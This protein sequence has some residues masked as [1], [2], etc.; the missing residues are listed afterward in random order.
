MGAV[1]RSDYWKKGV[2]GGG[3]VA[4]VTLATGGVGGRVVGGIT[5]SVGGRI[6]GAA[7][8]GSVTGVVADAGTQGVHISA[9]VQSEY[10]LER[11]GDAAL[12]GAAFGGGAAALVEGGVAANSAMNA[13]RSVPSAPSAAPKVG[14]D[15]GVSTD[16]AHG[17]STAPISANASEQAALG[18][19]AVES[20]V[21][22]TA[23]TAPSPA[24]SASK[25]NGEVVYQHRNESGEINYYGITCNP[26]LRA[27]Q[28]RAD[29]E[30]T[31]ATMEVITEPQ[32]HG[33]ARTVEAKLIRQRLAEAR[34]NGLIDGTE[35]IQEQLAKAGLLNKN[36][37]RDPVRWEGVDPEEV[38]VDPIDTFDIQT[39]E[40]K[41]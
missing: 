19:V 7:V 34:A 24:A 40:S 5:T 35:P 18:D 39:R 23:A 6:L 11:T 27:C 13:R 15:E 37:G 17:P 38:V 12:L 3:A 20:R 2:L 29:S 26:P 31:G 16:N 36:R 25:S 14:V 33:V 28:H 41:Q 10:D 1:S 8:V 4:A 22:S 32:T 9:G 30:K 21:G